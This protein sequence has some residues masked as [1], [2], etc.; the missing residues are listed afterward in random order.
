[1][2]GRRWDIDERGY[3]IASGDALSPNV[4][5]LA[6][7][8]RSARWVTEEPEAH[9]LP[10]L[11]AACAAP[12]SPWMISSWSVDESVLVIELTWGG[13]WGTWDML[14]ADAFSLL[15]PIAEHTTHVRQRTADDKVEFEVATGTLSGETPFVPHGHLVRLRIGPKESSRARSRHSMSGSS[16]DQTPKERGDG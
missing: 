5:E 1:M 13:P 4:E 3:G 16:R 12:G 6:D 11:E 2:D 9:L 7:A 10:H 8:M 15:G 14:R